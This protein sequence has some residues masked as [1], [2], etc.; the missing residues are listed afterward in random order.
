MDSHT[1]LQS[2]QPWGV[3]SP[4]VIL[5]VVQP[6]PRPTGHADHM[7]SPL[8]GRVSHHTASPASTLH[9]GRSAEQE[10]TLQSHLGAGN[11]Q[12]TP[13]VCFVVGV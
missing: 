5:R 13:D 7:L 2:L 3:L 9:L 12:A 10:R 11:V 6:H 8:P 1:K 4:V